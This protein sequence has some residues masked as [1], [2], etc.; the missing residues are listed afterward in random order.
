MVRFVWTNFITFAEVVRVVESGL[1]LEVF[2]QQVQD[3]IF[4]LA[5][6]ENFNIEFSASMV[7]SAE[8]TTLTWAHEDQK[9]LHP[10]SLK[11]TE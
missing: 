1:P 4:N 2:P 5:V 9:P 11:V 7:L 3:I 10:G 6:Y 8:A